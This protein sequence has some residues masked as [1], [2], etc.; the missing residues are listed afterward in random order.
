M[1]VGGDRETE[2]R[3][4]ARRVGLDRALGDGQATSDGGVGQ[5]LGDE[6]ENLGCGAGRCNGGCAP[7]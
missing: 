4:D 2:L 3:E 5:T 7:A 6:R 1:R